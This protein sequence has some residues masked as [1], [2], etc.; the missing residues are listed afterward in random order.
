MVKVL[1]GPD[2]VYEPAK[3]SHHWLKLKKGAKSADAA[4]GSTSRL[5]FAFSA[6]RLHGRPD[7]F[8]WYGRASWVFNCLF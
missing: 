6:C 3:R 7:R 1:D 2:A 4:L 5:F 8:V